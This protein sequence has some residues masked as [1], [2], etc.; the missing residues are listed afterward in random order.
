MPLVWAA[1]R[2]GTRFDTWVSGDLHLSAEKNR[3][4]AGRWRAFVFGRSL[5]EEFDTPT[6]A[7]AAAVRAAVEQ[8]QVLLVALG[9]AA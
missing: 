5:P 1:G 4:G 7:Q 6:D 9:A 3:D 8:V 2:H